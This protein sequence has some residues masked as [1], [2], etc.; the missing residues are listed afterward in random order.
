M[1]MSFESDNSPFKDSLVS[2]IM[3]CY[4]ASLYIEE[5]INSVL[6]Q[7][8]TNW[9][10]LIVDDGSTDSSIKI[11]K[12]F[13]EKDDRITCITE[14]NSGSAAAR[15]MAIRVSSGRYLAFLDSDDVWHSDYLS[16]MISKIQKD[17]CLSHAVFYSGYRRMNE[18]LSSPLLSNYFSAGVKDYKKLLR[19]CP[20][21]PSAA[22]VDRFRLK[23]CVLFRESLLSLRDD[24]VFF[25]DIL[26]QDL[27]CVGFKDILVDYRMRSNSCTGGSKRKM[28]KPQW[29][30]YHNVLKLSSVKSFYYLCIWA[31]NG[32]IKYG[33]IPLLVKG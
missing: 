7:K 12:S 14:E 4:N 21:F 1:Y 26:K 27:N 20:I 25:L 28:I 18:D 32:I 30:V 23:T 16:V 9:E 29:N 19:Y 24:Y 15:N 10:L 8:Y 6:N 17:K 11:I 33:K 3:P 31:F 22:I 5:T 13:M 2:I